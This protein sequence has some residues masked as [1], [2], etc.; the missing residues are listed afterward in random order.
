MK[1]KLVGLLLKLM[2]WDVPK[3]SPKG[4]RKAVICVGPHTSM[5]D[6]VVGKL[7]FMQFDVQE[8]FLLKKELFFPPLGWLLKKLG[9]IP[10]DR[11]SNVNLTDQAAAYFEKYESMFMIIPPEATRSYNPHWRTGFYYIA[12]KAQVPIYVTVLDYKTKTVGFVKRI[13]PT[14]NIDEDIAEIKEIL[15]HATGRYPKNGIRRVG[16]E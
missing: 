1:A 12:Q 16:D 10:T 2:G 13:E 5:W 6:F 8:T 11:R 15:S 9:G 4:V 14:G 3:T 7:I